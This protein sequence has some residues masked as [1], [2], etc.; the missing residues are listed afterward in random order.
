MIA[1]IIHKMSMSTVNDLIKAQGIYLFLGVQAGA[2]NT[3]LD[4]RHL[5]ER[6]FYCHNKFNIMEYIHS[7][8]DTSRPSRDPYSLSNPNINVRILAQCYCVA[9]VSL[10]LL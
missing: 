1:A 9:I 10:F 5:K 7:I 4:R 2:F 3:C 8:I 6:G